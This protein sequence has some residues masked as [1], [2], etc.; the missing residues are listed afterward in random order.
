MIYEF[1]FSHILVLIA[2]LTFVVIGL[3]FFTR[4]WIYRNKSFKAN[5]F[6]FR[7]T[8]L[9]TGFAIALV[10][11]FVVFNWTT[12]DSKSIVYNIDDTM[13]M[14]DIDI[15]ITQHEKKKLPKP[16]PP[17]IDLVPEDD[18]LEDQTEY[19]SM[20][21]S[22]D[23]MVESPVED[24][25]VNTENP[26]PLPSRSETDDNIPVVF[27]EQMPRF[28]GCENESTEVE[29]K[30]CSEQKLMQYIYGEL[31]YPIIAKENNIEGRTHI[32]FVVNK[33]GTVSNV[34][35]IRDI[36]GGCGEAA[37]D[38]VRSMKNLKWTPGKQGGRK[39]SV[40]YNLPVSFKLK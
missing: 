16:P 31:R 32:R 37:A 19:K 20:D 39:V 23:D 27:V 21:T 15:P 6:Q 8:F 34:E 9:L 36:G 29:R 4:Y 13:D 24:S 14:V 22:I 26:L 2:V 11:V 40:Y 18:I 12:L 5:V 7:G 35:I 3:V 10:F 33:S 38:V 17:I 30:L 1:N 25:P 28:P